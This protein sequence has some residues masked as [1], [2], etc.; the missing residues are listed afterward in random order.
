MSLNEKVFVVKNE[1]VKEV[2]I[3]KKIVILNGLKK[4]YQT[5]LKNGQYIIRKEAEKSDSFKQIIPYVIIHYHSQY[6]LF[7]RTK[8]QTE[9]R[10][11]NRYSLGVG[12]H[13]NPSSS[14]EMDEIKAGLYKEFFEEIQLEKYAKPKLI[15]LVYDE[16]EDV[17]KYHIG[18]FYTLEA[19]SNS[20]S[21]PEKDK[22]TA[23]W[24]EEP[25]LK[26]YYKGMESWS[27]IYIDYF[28]NIKRNKKKYLNCILNAEN[29]GVSALLE[30]IIESET[31]HCLIE[32]AYIGNYFK[33]NQRKE[34][35]WENQINHF[36]ESKQIA[37]VDKYMPIAMYTPS[38]FPD[39]VKE[40]FNNNVHIMCGCN[41]NALYNRKYREKHKQVILITGINDRITEIYD[42]NPTT[43]GFKFVDTE[44]L[45]AAIKNLNDGLWIISE[46]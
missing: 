33:K 9:S 40:L 13:I 42:P 31:E 14:K 8:A 17:G 12:G 23:E 34:V 45:F 39:V 22:M 26:K 30:M 19:K 38:D 44:D 11:H 37:L 4:I 3:N 36:F 16:S 7:K 41:L 21:L 10:L 2:M 25:D 15:A 35:G 28:V 6:L 24:V 20:F 46:K 18:L 29:N 43:G 32:H 1:I 27:R 5:I